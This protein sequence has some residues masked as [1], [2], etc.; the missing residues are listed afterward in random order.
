MAPDRI[1]NAAEKKCRTLPPEQKTSVLEIKKG[2]AIQCTPFFFCAVFA[3]LLH[4]CL[5]FRPSAG[6]IC[7]R[8]F[9]PA[10]QISDLAAI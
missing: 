9:A 5:F 8:T 1:W 7:M 10:L 6:N 4:R 2:R 3:L